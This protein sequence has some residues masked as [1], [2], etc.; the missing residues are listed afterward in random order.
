MCGSDERRLRTD[1]D[2][3]MARGSESTSFSW[4]HILEESS[5][6]ATKLRF[7]EPAS[8]L[9]RCLAIGAFFSRLAKQRSRLAAKRETS[10]ES[11]WQRSEPAS[12]TARLIA[13]PRVDN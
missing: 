4:D 9:G 8:R 12:T 3:S 10:L 6:S 2:W 5:S 1:A 7:V 13:A 11:C